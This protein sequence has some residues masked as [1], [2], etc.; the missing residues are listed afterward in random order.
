VLLYSYYAVVAFM[1]PI[2]LKAEPGAFRSLAHFNF[3]VWLGLMG[4][5]LFQYFLSMVIFL[6]VLTRLDA[7]Q[8]GLSNYLIPFFGVLI[9]A[10]VLRER[11]SIFMVLGGLLVLASTLL[12]TVYEERHRAHSKV[13]A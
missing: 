8:A 13:A 12:V 6:N 3:A 4:L 7:T 10:A 2:T 5:T 11:L 9:A 1:L